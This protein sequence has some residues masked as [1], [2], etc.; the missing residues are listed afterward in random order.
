MTTYN[1]NRH[2]GLYKLGLL[3]TMCFV[4]DKEY[5]PNQWSFKE[6]YRHHIWRIKRVYG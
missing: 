2:Y 4:N 5:D 1:S 6:R 3:E